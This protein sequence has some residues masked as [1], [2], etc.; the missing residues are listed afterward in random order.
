[1]SC[2]DEATGLRRYI[3]SG[4]QYDEV[5]PGI[6]L[7]PE[8]W[9]YFGLRL[10]AEAILD[11]RRL[12]SEE[13][14][15]ASQKAALAGLEYANFGFDDGCLPPRVV[16]RDALEW[17]EAH[18]VKGT[19]CLVHC[20][21]GISRSP[22]VVCLYLLPRFGWDLEETVRHLISRRREARPA[23]I[24]LDYL[25]RWASSHGCAEGSP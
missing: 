20:A 1:M 5:A 11:L 3:V 14:E 13:R 25:Q 18:Q 8:H 15:P 4:R 21:A 16:I 9:D 17:L 24:Y 6:L 22:F 7:G 19:P 12:N 23:R 10:I 2:R